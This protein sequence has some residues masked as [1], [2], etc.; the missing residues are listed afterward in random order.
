MFRA[1][2]LRSTIPDPD[3]LAR[4]LL[5]PSFSDAAHTLKR[6]DRSLV[7]AADLPLHPGQTPT[8]IIAKSLILDRLKDRLS[9]P[10]G[11]SSPQRQYRAA[12]LL[13]SRG[14][15]V[16][17]PLLLLHHTDQRRRVVHT[18]VT[19]R[20]PGESLL[21][22]LASSPLPL[23]DHHL[24]LAHSLGLLARRLIDAHLF[25]RD[26]KPSNIILALPTLTPTIIDPA[27]VRRIHPW[28]RHAAARRLLLARTLASLI[29]EPTGLG[30]PPPPRLRAIA[31][32]A[33]EPDRAARAALRRII[34]RL[35]LTHADPV[36]R[37]N[38]LTPTISQSPR[39]PPP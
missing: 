17:D 19:R 37:H 27:G 38:P 5:A 16:A 26:L 22:H 13:H 21:H 3:F 33:A 32:R 6:T 30:F 34:R 14:F 10:L 28:Q 1:R 23:S 12:L 9:R 36:P 31:L 29:L 24:R 15:A 20:I 7:L 35:I 18:L 4:A 39:K 11:L 25:N 8:P 2:I